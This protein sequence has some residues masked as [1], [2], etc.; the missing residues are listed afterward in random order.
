VTLTFVDERLFFTAIQLVLPLHEYVDPA[1]EP[2][3]FVTDSA[4]P[5][6]TVEPLQY[7]IDSAGGGVAPIETSYSKSYNISI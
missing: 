1:V 5:E 3:H 2:L 7:V 6:S 4:T